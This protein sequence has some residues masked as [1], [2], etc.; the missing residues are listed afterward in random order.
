MTHT[1]HIY[2]AQG[3]WHAASLRAMMD[4]LPNGDY[5]VKLSSASKKTTAQNG[6][7]HVLLEV[8]AVTLNGMGLGDGRQWTKDRVKQYAKAV[9]IYPVEDMRLPEGVV[10]QVP[11]DTRDLDQVQASETI[12]RLIQHFWEEFEIRLPGPNEQMEIAA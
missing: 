6:Y 9:E 4:N 3:K 8:I 12:E 11:V 5:T 1:H 2:K 10:V 7:L